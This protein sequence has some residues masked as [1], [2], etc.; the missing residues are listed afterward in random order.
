MCG[1]IGYS[2]EFSEELLNQGLSE[3]SHRGPDD[4][5]TYFDREKRIGLGH[6]RLSILD[7]SH[8]GHQPMISRDKSVV[9]L[10]NEESRM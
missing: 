5:G 2:G 10:F 9:L 6:C 4:R 8:L 3:I 7:V 1:L